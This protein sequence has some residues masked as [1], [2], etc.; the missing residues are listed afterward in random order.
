MELFFG[1]CN[2]IPLAAMRDNQRP[3]VWWPVYRVLLFSFHLL[4]SIRLVIC[5]QFADEVWR[6]LSGDVYRFLTTTPRT[7]SYASLTLKLPNSAMTAYLHTAPGKEALR[8]LLPILIR[9]H[10]AATARGLHIENA[11]KGSALLV[12]GWYCVIIYLYAFKFDCHNYPVAAWVW[13]SVSALWVTDTFIS[14][15]T[16]CALYLILIDELDRRADKALEEGGKLLAIG[17]FNTARAWNFVDSFKRV[18]SANADVSG[19]VGHFIGSLYTLFVTHSIVLYEIFLGAPTHEVI[20]LMLVMSMAFLVAVFVYPNMVGYAFNETKVKHLKGS[21]L[22]HLMIVF[23]L[24][25]SHEGN[26]N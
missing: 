11:L 17:I 7:L 1:I 21:F 4:T 23:Y 2:G 15:A 19:Y 20:R 26:A 12:L 16:F 6:N 18:I 8:R 9:H 22:R 10:D 5:A 24:G 3:S 25:G 13:G 14:L